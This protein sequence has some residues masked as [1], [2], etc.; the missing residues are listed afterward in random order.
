MTNAQKEYRQ[1]KDFLGEKQIEADVYYGI[2]TLRAKENFPITGYR[3]HEEMINA[4]AI[5]KKAAALANM[6]V[7]RLYEGIG[8]AIVQAA[9][10]ILEGKWHDQ[11]IVDPIQGGAGTS[12]NMNANE[13][14]GNRALEIMGHKK[15]EYIHLSPNTHVNMSQSTNDVFPTAIHISTLKLLDK[16]LDTM[17][18]MLS[19]FKDKAKQFDSVI[20]MG[21]THLQDAVPIR[22]GQ[23]FEAYSRVLERDIKRIKQSRQHL[24]EVNMG[25]TAVGTGLN[26]DPRYIEQVVKHLADISGLPLVGAGHLVDATQNTDA[27]TEV[28]AALKV[29]MMNMSKIAN[30]LRLMASGPRAGLA[31]ISL[32]ARQPGSSIMPGKVNPVMA[33]LINQIAFQVIGNDNTICLAS[34]AGQ[35]ELNVMEP[36]LVFNLLQSISIMNNGFRSFTDHCLAGIE[37]NEKRLKQ[38]VEKS[39]GVI[40]A[41]NPHL[42]YE[43]AARI[44]RE[45]IMTGK[46]VR[47]LC[48]QNDVL[49]EE[50]LDIILNPYEMTKPGIAGKDLLEK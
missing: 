50:E 49:T 44:A 16:L 15:G 17:A 21:R 12:M 39:V 4:L 19:V 42:G 32:P 20:K 13:V 29:C 2:Q 43:A 37:A 8:N 9:D 25:A 27:Y 6:D 26:A 38:Y 5:V 11:F 3:I 24:Y 22:L 28:S 45:A 46:S 47:D 7:K 41:V 36:V 31:E 34:E 40:T 10:E 33:E 23:E 30:D 1:E 14:I 48:L 18:H 35:L